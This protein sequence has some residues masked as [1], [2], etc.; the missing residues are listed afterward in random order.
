MAASASEIPRAR[1]R[2]HSLAVRILSGVVLSLVTLFCVWKGGWVF[3]ALA[4]AG[5]LLGLWEFLRMGVRGGYP[6]LMVPG[7]AAGAAV[8]TLSLTHSAG[9]AGVVLLAIGVWMIGGSLRSP[10]DR[11]LVA[12]ALSVLG[13]LYVVG[14]GLHLL[15][16]REMERGL[17]LMVVVLL[18]TWAADTFAFFVGV[19]FGKTPLLPEVSPGK[20]VEGLWGG[21]LGAAVTVV[22]AMHFLL[23]ETGMTARVLIGLVI[24][25][26]SPLGDLLESM[27]KRNLG[28][29]DASQII[30]GHGGVLDRID[31]LLLTAPATF[32]LFRFLT[33]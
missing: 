16:L 10:V 27:F 3:S 18:G 1:F 28:I 23:P 12:L 25:V 30:P 21:I 33:N 19:R 5:L 9:N 15:W 32:Y 22:V 11:R 31:S 13:V 29:K 8:L 24:G 4:A 17:P 7:M 2:E 6:M 20:S 26:M 14:L